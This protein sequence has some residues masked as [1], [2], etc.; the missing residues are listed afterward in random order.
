MEGENDVACLVL[1]KITKRQVVQMG[2]WEVLSFKKACQN[3][4]S[5]NLIWITSNFGIAK[6]NELLSSNSFTNDHETVEGSSPQLDPD[7]PE[8]PVKDCNYL[9]MKRKLHCECSAK[10][11]PDN[12]TWRICQVFNIQKIFFKHWPSNWS[13]KIQMLHRA[14][15]DFYLA[16]FLVK[17][18]YMLQLELCALKNHE[19]LS[20]WMHTYPQAACKKANGFS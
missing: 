5:N 12:R 18:T 15:L 4:D 11:T 20:R 17:L 3:L 10:C 7:Y 1:V 6:K 9:P 2:I 14:S 8:D 19:K 16:S 13:H